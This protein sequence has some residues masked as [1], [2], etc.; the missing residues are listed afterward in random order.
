M[1]KCLRIFGDE[2]E[3]AD[4]LRDCMIVCIG[5]FW[6]YRLALISKNSR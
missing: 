2:K 5:R 4:A 3:L 1:F 6:D